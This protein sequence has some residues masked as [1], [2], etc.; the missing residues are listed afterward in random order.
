MLGGLRPRIKLLYEA[1]NSFLADISS[2]IQL[3][4]W[5]VLI[6]IHSPTLAIDKR[7]SLSSNT[8]MEG[9]YH[10]VRQDRTWDKYAMRCRCGAEASH[11]FAYA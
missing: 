2:R 11:R 5:E 6:I 8:A 3:K 10:R 9:G 1:L 4:F 7:W